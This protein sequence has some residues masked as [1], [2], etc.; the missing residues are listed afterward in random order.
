MRFAV[1]FCFSFRS[2]PCRFVQLRF[3]SLR[4]VSFRA[5]K[6]LPVRFVTFRYDSLRFV[7]FR[8]VSFRQVTVRVVREM[9]RIRHAACTTQR[10]RERVL[11][12]KQPWALKLSTSKHGSVVL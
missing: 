8:V 7:A 3:V 11:L 5:C 10:R 4:L 9:D 12:M 6:R 1:L 2:V